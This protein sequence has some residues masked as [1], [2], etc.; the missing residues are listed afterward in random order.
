MSNNKRV[1]IISD[2]HCP[3][4]HQDSFKFLKA[5]KKKYKPT[6]VINV[7]DEVD[8]HGISFHDSDPDLMSPG[9]ELIAAQKACKELEKIFP[10]MELCDS[11]HGS[12]LYRRGKAG[13]IPRH[14]LKDYADVLNVGSGWTWHSEIVV[15]YKDFAPVVVRHQFTA[16]TL[17]NAEQM[18]CSIVQG[19]HHSKLEVQWTSSPFSVHYGITVGCLIDKESLAFSY[20]KLQVKRPILGSGIIIDGMP[21]VIPMILDQD[22]RWT[23]RL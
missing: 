9:D 1:L 4:H 8:G 22:G 11:N 16:N 17:K 18:G 15:N 20:N 21:Q 7:G 2:L 6:R 10:T 12:L 13:G 23:G 14:M 3:Y 19:H 5:L